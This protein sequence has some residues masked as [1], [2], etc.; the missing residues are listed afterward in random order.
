MANDG[1]AG[2]GPAFSVMEN[3]K[4]NVI[5]LKTAPKNKR[6]TTDTLIFDQETIAGWRLPPFQRERRIND[7]VRAMAEELKENGGVVNG[8]L[9][10]G[11]IDGDKT[12]W[13]VDGQ[14]RIE[15]FKLSGIKEVIADVRLMHF[16]SMNDMAD[17]FVM[18][19]SQLVKMRPDDVLRG[20]EPNAPGLRLLRQRCEFVGYGQV[21][22]DTYSAMVS[23]AQV[24]RCWMASGN[25]TPSLSSTGKG[26]AALVEEFTVPEAEACIGFLMVCN[27]AW[28]R[29]PENY[30]LWASLNLLVCMWVYRRVVLAQDRNALK[31]SV[32]LNRDQ[33]KQ[34][35]MSLSADR[36]FIDW[37]RGRVVGERDRSPC[38]NRMKAIFAKRLAAEGL[39]G[40]IK[41]PMAA[42]ASS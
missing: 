35:L 32:L 30:R 24:I 39:P 3:T 8:V 42:W 11:Y 23:A 7:K 21:R 10:L 15:A 37:L 29:E 27:S 34:C 28:G 17:E 18:L 31:R 6:S 36:D 38:Y 26:V 40:T 20:M 5:K 19:N 4:M 33:F 1:R 16:E 14:H 25:E 13:L 9:T 41:F 2:N 12:T 22:R